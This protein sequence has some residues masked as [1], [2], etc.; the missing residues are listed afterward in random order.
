MDGKLTLIRIPKERGTMCSICE[1]RR[2]ARHSGIRPPGARWAELLSAYYCH[3]SMSQVGN[4]LRQSKI[5]RAG[6]ACA[7]KFTFQVSVFPEL[8]HFQLHVAFAD[9]PRGSANSIG[10]ALNGINLAL[11]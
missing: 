6:A 9:C 11:A 5:F 1:R 8:L 2:Q 10:M 3:R 7:S 4:N